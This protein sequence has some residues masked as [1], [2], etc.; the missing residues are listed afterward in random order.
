MSEARRLSGTC[1]CSCP[2]LCLRGA[3]REV[4]S[5]PEPIDNLFDGKSV[6]LAVNSPASKIL[7]WGKPER[8]VAPFQTVVETKMLYFLLELPFHPGTGGTNVVEICPVP[9]RLGQGMTL[10]PN[11]VADL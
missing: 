4:R 10:L 9:S 8:A 5:R 3:L 11:P 6:L 1:L 2:C 7:E